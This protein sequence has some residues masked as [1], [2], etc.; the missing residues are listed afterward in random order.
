MVGSMSNFPTYDYNLNY[1]T[2]S[3]RILHDNVS[4]Y[5]YQTISKLMR[6]DIL[7]GT[8]IEVNGIATRQ[9]YH[10]QARYNTTYE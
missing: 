1:T 3:E 9:N 10:A 4:T 2:T 8:R 7:L 5:R 6:P